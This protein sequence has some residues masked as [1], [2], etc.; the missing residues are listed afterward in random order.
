MCATVFSSFLANS[1]VRTLK[2]ALARLWAEGLRGLR[3]GYLSKFESTLS[4]H[5]QEKSLH[6][7]CN[8]FVFYDLFQLPLAYPSNLPH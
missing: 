5:A 1:F 2:P 7:V 4:L 8:K 3:G 6:F